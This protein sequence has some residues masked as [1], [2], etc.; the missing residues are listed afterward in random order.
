MALSRNPV[1]YLKRKGIVD[2]PARPRPRFDPMALLVNTIPLAS[3]PMPI[4]AVLASFEGNPPADRGLT[5]PWPG[6]SEPQ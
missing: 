3:P 1:F 5:T 6:Q 4:A 2:E